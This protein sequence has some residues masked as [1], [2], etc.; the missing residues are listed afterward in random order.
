MA[1]VRNSPGGT[2]TCPPPARLQAV[3]AAANASVHSLV[4]SP[5]AP[6]RVTG[7][8]RPGKRG[9]RTEATI[10]SAARFTAERGRLDGL[11]AMAALTFAAPAQ[12][13]VKAPAP[14]RAE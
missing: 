3:I 8:N 4:P 1:P 2:T 14:A 5:T 12:R 9:R 7:N 10:R 11:P 13:L 6:K